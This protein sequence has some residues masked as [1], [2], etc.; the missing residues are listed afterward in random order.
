MLRKYL[1][2]LAMA[3]LAAVVWASPY[4]ASALAAQHAEAAEDQHRGSNRLHAR[5]RSSLAGRSPSD[6]TQNP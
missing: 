2:I 4:H 1:R 5:R 6:E 3:L